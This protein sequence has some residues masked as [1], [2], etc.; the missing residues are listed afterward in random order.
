MKDALHP[1][2][3]SLVRR[4]REGDAAAFEELFRAHYEALVRYATSLVHSVEAARDVVCEIYTVIWETA[5]HWSPTN[6]VR[7]YLFGAVRNRVLNLLRD[8][9]RRETLLLHRSIDDLPI[10]ASMDTTVDDDLERDEQWAA[11]RCTIDDMRGIRGEAM[12]LRWVHQLTQ[13][14]VASALGISLNAVQ[15]HLSLALKVLRQQFGGN[16]GTGPG[17]AQ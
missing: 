4:V 8:E 6:G 10:P 17:N 5:D 11:I 3:A 13:A 1:D 9:Q 14:E 2:D 15:Q 16:S 12:R 7:A